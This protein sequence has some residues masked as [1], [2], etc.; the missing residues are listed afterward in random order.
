MTGIAGL[1]LI[2]FSEMKSVRNFV[3]AL[4]VPK[5]AIKTATKF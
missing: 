5:P 4:H 3:I 2:K 1:W